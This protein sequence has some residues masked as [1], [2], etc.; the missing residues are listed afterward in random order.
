MRR[1]NVGLI[2]ALLLTAAAIAASP[3]GRKVL[4]LQTGHTPLHWNCPPGSHGTPR[5]TG[6]GQSLDKARDAARS[7]RAITDR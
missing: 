1:K 3:P 7:S 4:G 5:H 6:V 2:A